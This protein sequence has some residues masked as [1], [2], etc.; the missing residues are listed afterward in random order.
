M[1]LNPQAE[2]SELYIHGFQTVVICPLGV[3]HVLELK[4]CSTVFLS[5]FNQNWSMLINF[6][7]TPKCKMFM[8]I[9]S[10]DPKLFHAHVQR[11]IFM[12]NLQE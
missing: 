3:K 1:K 6:S 9:C 10:A 7:K 4:E 2:V 12:G 8:K 5:D 11:G